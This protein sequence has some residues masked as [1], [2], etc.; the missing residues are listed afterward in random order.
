MCAALWF[1]HS[2]LSDFSSALATKIQN[3]HIFVC[4]H[5]VFLP[6]QIAIPNSTNPPQTNPSTNYPGTT[7][8]TQPS[9]T[10]QPTTN[11]PTAGWWFQIFFIFTPIWGRFPFW[12]IFFKGVV[13]V[14]S[15]RALTLRWRWYLEVTSSAAF[16]TRRRGSAN[17]AGCR[18]A[19]G[20]AKFGWISMALKIPI[21]KIRGEG[22][23]M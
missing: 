22:E 18:G 11:Q 16:R 15:I 6:P 23:K 21:G 12:L 8:K 9:P 3:L 1:I 2:P 17:L 5:L 10:N 4:F 7:T 14:L 19:N 20:R 13:I